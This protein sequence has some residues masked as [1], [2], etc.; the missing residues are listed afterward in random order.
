M[1][2]NPTFFISGR[3]R[4]HLWESFVSASRT[5][6]G[7]SWTSP[8]LG[9]SGVEEV[10]GNAPIRCIQV[11]TRL[12][13]SLLFG[14]STAGRAIRSASAL[15]LVG[16]N[17]PLT[18]GDTRSGEPTSGDPSPE[19]VSDT[20]S[21]NRKPSPMRRCA[22]VRDLVGCV[23]SRQG[24]REYR[25]GILRVPELLRCDVQGFSLLEMPSSDGCSSA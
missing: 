23:E 9:V 13:S 12:D 6:A 10:M 24:E 21:S 15:L 17:H 8:S 20:R 19:I 25:H 16:V 7:T 22:E 2:V 5:V 4:L 3:P 1:R 11:P 18:G 14:S